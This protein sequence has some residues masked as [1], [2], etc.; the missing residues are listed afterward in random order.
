[1]WFENVSG[2]TDCTK[3]IFSNWHSRSYF[4]LPRKWRTEKHKNT[5][6]ALNGSTNV[7][8]PQATSVLCVVTDILNSR[9]A[10][11]GVA[12]RHEEW[13]NLGISRHLLGYPSRFWNGRPYTATDY[14]HTHTH[15][16]KTFRRT[17]LWLLRF[18]QYWRTPT[19]TVSPCSNFTL[20]LIALGALHYNPQRTLPNIT[21]KWQSLLLDIHH[22]TGSKLS[23][24]SIFHKRGF[25][26][27]YSVSLSKI[28]KCTWN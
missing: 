26:W 25:S 20:L 9:S 2:P 13:C 1:V 16:A 18:Q 6:K 17:A 7:L 10:S 28:R 23:S 27:F 24:G 21:N 19:C 11:H 8:H 3:L 12:F 15:S 4:K 5:F 14:T 22:A